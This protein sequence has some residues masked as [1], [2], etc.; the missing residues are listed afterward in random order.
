MAVEIRRLLCDTEERK[1]D[2]ISHHTSLLTLAMSEYLINVVSDF[3][4]VEEKLLIRH[5]H[6]RFTLNTLCD[7]F[8]LSVE[9]KL[10]IPESA[11][12]WSTLDTEAGIL[13]PTLQRQLKIC[14]YRPSRRIG[15]VSTRLHTASV[16]K[17]ISHDVVGRVLE[18]PVVPAGTPNLITQIKILD[19]TMSFIDMQ[20]VEHVWHSVKIFPLPPTFGNLQMEK[21]KNLG[22]CRL[23]AEASQ[24]IYLCIMCALKRRVC[25]LKHCCS[26]NCQEKT[27][28]CKECR[29]PMQKINL[30]GRILQVQK[31]TYFLC[32][33]C[34]APTRWTGAGLLQECSC[35]ETAPHPIS[36]GCHVC[37][38]RTIVAWRQC[39][40]VN[41]LQIKSIPLCHRHAKSCIMSKRTVYDIQS[42]EKDLYSKGDT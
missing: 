31:K 30:I 15:L 24:L 14:N 42:L 7:Q 18:L 22:S 20:A 23:L 25:V 41:L 11:I 2:F 33:S 37:S 19:P 12:M 40:D 34:L 32:P 29:G 9:T 10:D 38:H 35:T 3:C 13:L 26:Y 39:I 21:I 8:R 36:S 6:C 28:E 16:V 17:S 27:L 4:P 1:R 5:P